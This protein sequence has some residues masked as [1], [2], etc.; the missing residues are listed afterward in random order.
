MTSCLPDCFHFVCAYYVHVWENLLM[1]RLEVNVKRRQWRW[2]GGK[3]IIKKFYIK[4]INHVSVNEMSERHV[5]ST[6]ERDLLNIMYYSFRVMPEN[7]FL[8]CLHE[9]WS[10]KQRGRPGNMNFVLITITMDNLFMVINFL[11]LISFSEIFLCRFARVNGFHV[12]HIC[13]L[14]LG[15]SADQLRRLEFNYFTPRWQSVLRSN[16]WA[17]FWIEKHFFFC[18]CCCCVMNMNK[19][20]VYARHR[21]RCLNVEQ[22]ATS[23]Q[24]LFLSRLFIVVSYCAI[25]RCFMLVSRLLCY[26]LLSRSLLFA[27]Q[28]NSEHGKRTSF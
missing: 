12:L 24:S 6:S 18:C 17:D 25:T 5:I 3:I 13:S 16:L 28:Q 19:N 7:D 26:V 11:V 20:V 22:T 23:L 8:T 10:G 15:P 1:N 4:W 14:L 27:L 2:V 9:K 21:E